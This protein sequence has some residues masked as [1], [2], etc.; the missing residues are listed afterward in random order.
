MSGALHRTFNFRRLL[1]YMFST[2]S[3]LYVSQGSDA[4]FQHLWP[5]QPGG[6]RSD[7]LRSDLRSGEVRHCTG[8]CECDE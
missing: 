8:H 1:W 6:L 4:A 5:S 2:C 3:M 7:T